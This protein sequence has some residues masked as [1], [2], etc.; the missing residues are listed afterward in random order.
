MKKGRP[1]VKISILCE[2]DKVEKMKEVLF[3]ETTTLGVRN[4]KVHKTMLQR[5]FVKVNTSFGEVTV[6]EAYYKGEKIKSK[7]EYEEC[8]KIARSTGSPINQVYEKLRNEI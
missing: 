6:K 4:F 8:K 7:F 2:E 5:E 3:R 1:S